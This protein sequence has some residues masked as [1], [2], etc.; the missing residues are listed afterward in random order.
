MHKFYQNDPR[1]IFISQN[2]NCQDIFK[3]IKVINRENFK[4]L[5]GEK[6]SNYWLYILWQYTSARELFFD[7]EAISIIPDTHIIQA[8]F[9]LSLI[10]KLDEKP[11][12]VVEIW[13]KAL[14]NSNFKG[15]DLHPVLWNWSRNNFKPEV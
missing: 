8:S 12:R 9:K 3:L 2:W 15:I 11:E 6:L 10:D 7:I 4:Y 1:N 5:R 14:E 13:L